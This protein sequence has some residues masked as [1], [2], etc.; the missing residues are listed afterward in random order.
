MVE[1]YHMEFTK[2]TN[3]K[4]KSWLSPVQNKQKKRLSSVD[5]NE[6][7]ILKATSEDIKPKTGKNKCR[8]SWK[9][10][11][12]FLL[13]NLYAIYRIDYRFAN[14]V[15]NAI[16]K[17]ACFDSFFSKLRKHPPLK[18]MFLFYSLIKYLHAI[19]SRQHINDSLN[20]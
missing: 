1:S 13:Q 2:I 5:S 15:K 17:G 10:N 16:F 18:I 6:E 8:F 4:I 14:H 20:T 11:N 19:Y 9:L 7:I 3:Q 12:I